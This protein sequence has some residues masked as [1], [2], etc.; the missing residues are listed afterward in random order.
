MSDDGART[1]LVIGM[2]LAEIFLLILFV[3]WWGTDLPS[4]AVGQEPVTVQLRVIQAERDRLAAALTEIKSNVSSL[5]AN[6]ADREARL[7]A[8]RAMLGAS[9]TDTVEFRRAFDAELSDV[10]AAARRGSPKCIPSNALVQVAVNNGDVRL[11]LL[12]R[13]EDVL[14]DLRARG[15]GTIE[16]GLIIAEAPQITALL[17][18][19]ERYYAAHPECRFDYRLLYASAADYKLGRTTFER[20]F[21]PERIVELPK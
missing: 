21:Y 2:T 13:D 12:C 18:A 8:L 11:T 20:F 5:Q 9:S 3:I 14:A 4:S 16:A 17:T 19:V 7:E 1:D 6:L 10:A 15:A